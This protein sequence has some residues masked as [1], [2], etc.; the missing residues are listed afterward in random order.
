MAHKTLYVDSSGSPKLNFGL[1]KI[2]TS[3]QNSLF[4]Q[5]TLLVVL[6]RTAPES[7]DLEERIAG[8]AI[9]VFGIKS[10]QITSGLSVEQKVDGIPF[11]WGKKLH[12]QVVPLRTY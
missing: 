4:L 2:I 6:A 10:P 3:G 5:E 11:G 8:F 7:I 12:C 1:K 9:G